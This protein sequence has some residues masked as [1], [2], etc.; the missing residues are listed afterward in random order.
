MKFLRNF[1]TFTVL[2]L[3]VAVSLQTVQSQELPAFGPKSNALEMVPANVY[4]DMKQNLDR[5]LEAEF[6]ILDSLQNAYSYFTNSQQPFVYYPGKS[7]LVTIK[8][9]AQPRSEAANTLDDLFILT[10]EDWGHTWAA[11]VQVYESDD[12]PGNMARY[13]S[14][15]AFEYEDALTFV[16]TAPLTNGSGWYG[17]VNGL[18]YDG[19][20]PTV[21][22]SFD[23]DGT[24]YGWGGTDSKIVG[25]VIDADPFGL[26]VGNLM[27]AGGLPLSMTSSIG[28][29]FTT[30]FDS[31]TPTIPDAWAANK[32][33][34]PVPSGSYT[35]SLRTSLTL[36]L[37][38]D[39]SNGDLY[40]AAF[41]R[42][43]TADN[44]EKWLP[45]MSKSEDNGTSWSDY[46]VFPWQVISDYVV[47]LGVNPDAVT[48]DRG[49]GDFVQLPGGNYS[50][51]VTI[52]E[53]TTMTGT[54]YAYALHKIVELY[55]ENSQ[56]G[57][58][59]IADYSGYFLAYV[60]ATGNN[61]MGNELMVSRT[62]DGSKLLAKWVDFVSAIDQN[63][64]TIKYYT[65]DIFVAVRD[66]E[67][68]EWSRSKD[69]TESEIYDRI[70]WIPDFIPNDLKDIPVLKLESIPNP[71]DTPEE[72]RQRQ[73]MLET[74]R[75]YVMLYNFDADDLLIVGV[76]DQKLDFEVGNVY[77]NPASEN[78][79]LD[80]NLPENG[81]MNID[82]IDLFGRTVKNVY[83]GFVNGGFSALNLNLGNQAAGT[84]FF[85]IN[86]NGSVTTKTINIIK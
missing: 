25:G 32:Y 13:P 34:E 26:A 24:T 8:R 81:Q 5:P 35:D 16:Y 28:Q 57:I 19:P 56:F 41:A 48:V 27:P 21:Q 14:V 1:I 15:F 76:E 59:P 72:A 18:Y 30:S 54:P 77:P 73:R 55:H 31:W 3:I 52:N 10:S 49:A 82:L 67:K 46:E 66:I 17:F 22:S 63:G 44:S 9:G 60:G 2:F 6:R 86:Y 64:D 68:N 42:F 38:K 85:R 84:Y 61:Q 78:V 74:E 62:V 83:N 51:I 43:K 69:I 71:N 7:L 36:S 20:I 58:R 53:D 12:F 80:L 40:F 4:F 33:I 11:P 50:F 39:W 45:G 29:R 75:Q 70:T 37:K 65:T 23:I 47:G 79:Y